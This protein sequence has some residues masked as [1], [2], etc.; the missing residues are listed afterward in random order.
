MDHRASIARHFPPETN[1]NWINEL[2]LLAIS[3]QK[4]DQR[5]SIARHLKNKMDQRTSIARHFPPETSRMDQRVSIARHFAWVVLTNPV[6]QKDI[7]LS[8]LP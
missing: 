5:V 7:S 8:K 1:K 2:V 4:M 3:H 6:F